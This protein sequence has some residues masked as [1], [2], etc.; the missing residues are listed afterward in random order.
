MS[1]LIILKSRY[2][3]QISQESRIFIFELLNLKFDK[4]KSN[5]WPKP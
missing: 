4:K 5:L 1:K 2:S 3:T